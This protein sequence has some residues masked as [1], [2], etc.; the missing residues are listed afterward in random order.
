MVDELSK[1]LEAGVYDEDIKE[2]D[3][4]KGR[5][6]VEMN[7]DRLVQMVKDLADHLTMGL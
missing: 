2:V 1:D 4:K 5:Q 6:I 3:G 7:R